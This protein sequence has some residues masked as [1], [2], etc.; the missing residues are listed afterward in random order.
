M[1]KVV[2]AIVAVH[3]GIPPLVNLYGFLIQRL[4][5]SCSVPI[6]KCTLPSLQPT[7]WLCSTTRYVIADLWMVESDSFLPAL[8]ITDLPILSTSAAG[9]F[10][11]I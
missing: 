5:L 7:T 4:Y 10:L 3:G 9:K 8:V 2:F 6:T 11:D 1:C